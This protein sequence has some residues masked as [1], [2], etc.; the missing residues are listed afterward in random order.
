MPSFDV[1]ILGCGPAGERAAIH[2]SRAGKR[3]A[4]VERAGVVGGNRVNWGTIPSKTLRESALYVLGLRRAEIHGIRAE[5]K[6]E[7]TV[8]DFMFR[9]RLVKQRELELINESLDR[10]HIEVFKGHGRFVDEHTVAITGVDGQVRTQLTGAFILIATGSRP[11]HPGDVPFDGQTVFDSESILALPRM[12]RSMLVLGAGVVGIEYASIFAA[13]GLQVTLVDT[14]ERLLPYC[15]G[16][17]VDILE[18]ELRRLG[19]VVL[20]NDRHQAIE[21]LE[22]KR[23]RCRTGTGNV[24]EADVLLYCVGRD[25]NTADLG[26]ET[27]GLTPN[28]YGL[29]EVNDHFQT[30]H[31]HIYAAG[32]VIG[33]PAL[34]STSM[35]QGRLAMRHAFNIP[36]VPLKTEVL[37]FAAYSIPEISYVG[38]SEETLKKAGTGYVVGR[39]RYDAN[40]RG[41]IIGDL[42]GVLKLL[43][44][45]GTLKLLGVHIIGTNASELVH[46]GLAFL[47][48]HATAQQIA[49]T[50][51]NYPT[52]SDLYRHAALK[53]ITEGGRRRGADQADG[54]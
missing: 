38:A 49:E 17:L 10:Y 41:Q 48:N 28:A 7:I 39:G 21:R 22:G 29:L 47:R 2:A 15:D 33:Y 11:H 46:I 24:L 36:G 43:F 23:V 51:F 40:P 26:L 27:V 54:G 35:E 52:L 12:P 19:V 37:P 34:A 42:G 5:F 18:R 8:A 45:E 44:E 4:V 53:A 1:V 30:R 25:G 6:E 31:P 14:R 32:D 20:H 3:V 16:E 50:L 9:E 13:L